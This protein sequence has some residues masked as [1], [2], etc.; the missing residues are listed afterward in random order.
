M[1]PEINHTPRELSSI[2]L[3]RVKETTEQYLGRRVPLAVVTILAYFN[4][5]QQQA[6]K[7]GGGKI[8]GLDFLHVISELT[9]SALEYRWVMEPLISL[10]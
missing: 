3:V 10:S 1:P 4:N 6:T 5:A 8:A 9:A 2:I 7:D